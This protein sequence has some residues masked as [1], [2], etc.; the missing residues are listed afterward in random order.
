MTGTQEENEIFPLKASWNDVG[1]KMG[2]KTTV[3]LPLKK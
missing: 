2:R 1:A 3:T